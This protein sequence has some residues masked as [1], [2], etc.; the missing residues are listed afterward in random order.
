MLHVRH[1][2]IYFIRNSTI[3]KATIM[4]AMENSYPNH[5]HNELNVYDIKLQQLCTKIILLNTLYSYGKAAKIIF[6]I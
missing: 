6:K 3:N 2:I 4:A 1:P 5:I